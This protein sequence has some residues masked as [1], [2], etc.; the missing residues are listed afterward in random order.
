MICMPD[1]TLTRQKIWN[2]G[3]TMTSNQQRDITTKVQAQFSP[4]ANAYVAS[5]VH[6]QGKDFARM[7]AMA[8]TTGKERVLDVAT[9][10]GHTALAFAPHVHHVV[11]SDLTVAMLH[12]A[13]EHIH[14]QGRQNVSYC[15]AAAEAL[16]FANASF[17]LVTCRVAAHHFADA[18]AFT[19]EAA[20]LL[21]PGGLL[22]ISDHIGLE[23]MELD[24]FM[25]RFERWRDPGHVRAYTFR[26]WETFC[27]R[28]GLTLEHTE[29]IEW[30]P[31]EFLSWAARIQM[32]EQERDALEQWLLAAPARCR[33]YFQ[34][35]EH[36]GRVVSLR[37]MFGL[38]V[39]QR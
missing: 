11:A 33:E 5:S 23:D 20:R 35:V 36:E 15:R 2:K 8:A 25:D 9:G 13:R 27:R 31:Y 39:A 16:P 30:E 1:S 24:A 14:S 26:E 34:V 37:S 28:A 22:I 3:N 7:L 32:P 38:V 17:E 10:G 18:A 19:A 21:R 29:D 4:V 6:A 12:A